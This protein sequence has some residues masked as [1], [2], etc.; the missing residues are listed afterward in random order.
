MGLENSL[1]YCLAS[2]QIR[3]L[4]NRGQIKASSLDEPRIQPSSYEP[5]IGDELFV[6]DTET[7]GLFR[8]KSNESVYRTLLRLPARQRSRVDISSGFE[9]KRGFTYMFHLEDKLQLTE[10]LF[11]KSSPKSSF[12][13]LFLNTRMLADFNS[14]FDEIS[15]KCLPQKYIDLWLL[16]QPLVFN[17]IAYPGITFTQLRFIAGYGAQLTAA[18]IAEEIRLNPILFKAN[19]NGSLSPAQSVLSDGLEI[20]LDLSGRNTQGI[21]GL[22]ARHN[23]VPIDLKKKSEYEAEDFFEP[24]KGDGKITVNRGNHYLLSSE[25]ILRI[26]DYLNVELRSHSHIGFHGPLHFAGFIDNGFEGDLVFEVR[27]DELSNMVLE[28]RMPVSKLDLFRTAKP[29]K[30]YG[31][32]IGSNYQGQAGP[33]PSKHFRQFDF[34]YAARNYSKLDR[35]VLVQEANILKKHRSRDQGFEFLLNDKVEKLY[36]DISNGFFHSRYDCENDQ[37]IL[38][39]IPY[40]LLFGPNETVFSYVRAKNIKDYGDERL[41][42]K[43]SIG[44]GGHIVEADK[45]DYVK[46][47]L[48]REV[49]E[50]EVEIQGNISEPKLV[51]TL[52]AY[53]N[54]VDRVHYGLIFAT[55]VDGTVKPKESSIISGEMFKIQSLVSDDSHPL[56]Y[57]TWS[58]ILMCH[59]PEICRVS[60]AK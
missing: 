21:V 46:R 2:Q 29:D 36:A 3:E 58:R 43:H 56:K 48:R 1:G 11:V 44:L 4:I 15:P 54:P 30:L 31:E 41:F 13:R 47:C 8:P 27:P 52:M 9:L 12:G 6:L 38:Q 59:L 18:E 24:V 5:E 51:G 39:P 20:H 10:S 35:L 16:V 53:D 32:L 49:M 42:G 26:P 50:E 55:H 37:L 7:R 34:S 33:R 25:E 57:E 45:P 22:R 14:S 40:V 28:D 17:V 60:A 23:P 19:D